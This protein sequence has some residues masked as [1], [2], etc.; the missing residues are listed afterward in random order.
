[1]KKSFIV[2]MSVVFLA[3][4]GGNKDKNAENATD[5]VVV[6]TNEVVVAEDS[7]ALP[8]ESNAQN[9]LDY[10]GTYTGVLPTASGEGMNVTIT[11]TDST[12]TKEISYV[13]KKDKPTLTKGAYKWDAAGTIITLEG[14]EKPNQYFVGENTLTQRDVDGNAIT[15]DIASQYILKKK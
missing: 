8:D 13:G 2:L 14:T 4:C 1:M 7:L 10:Q 12:Y 5:D 3:S 15:G 9:A 6:T 11:L